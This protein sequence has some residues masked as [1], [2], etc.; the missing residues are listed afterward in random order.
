MYTQKLRLDIFYGLNIMVNTNDV[1]LEV[2]CSGKTAKE[3]VFVGELVDAVRA[4]SA[5]RDGSS[6]RE[7]GVMVHR[8]HV[9]KMNSF[10]MI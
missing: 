4:D 3:N 10:I 9:E 7:E 5:L 8:V 1:V 6:R 2:A